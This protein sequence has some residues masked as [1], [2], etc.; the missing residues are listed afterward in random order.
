MNTRA[1]KVA[2]IVDGG[3]NID[4]VHRLW[5][6]SS[7]PCPWWKQLEHEGN[8]PASSTMASKGSLQFLTM[9]TGKCALPLSLKTC[10]SFPVLLGQASCE[11]D[12]DK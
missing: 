11:E 8:E 6:C 5:A 1:M 4:T 2:A 7:R 12:V 10:S 3:S 9:C